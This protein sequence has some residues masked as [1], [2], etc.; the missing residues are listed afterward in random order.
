[1]DR[2]VL[3]SL[4]NLSFRFAHSNAE[5]IEKFDFCPFAWSEMTTKFTFFLETLFFNFWSLSVVVVVSLLRQERMLYSDRGYILKFAQFSIQTFSLVG[6]STYITRSWKET[7]SKSLNISRPTRSRVLYA[8]MCNLIVWTGFVVSTFF[9]AVVS[10][11]FSFI[12]LS[13]FGEK[14]EVCRQTPWISLTTP[15]YSFFFGLLRH[16]LPLSFSLCIL[17]LSL[18][19]SPCFHTFFISTLLSS[20]FSVGLK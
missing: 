17:Y 20:S 6:I 5:R 4:E 1:M 11:H 9:L 15:F 3:Y 18:Y 8:P 13:V 10:P 16:Y 12:Q 19:P 2:K 14:T 7:S